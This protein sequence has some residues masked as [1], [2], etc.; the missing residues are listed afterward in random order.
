MSLSS[1][2]ST[3]YVYS[4]LVTRILLNLVK[5]KARCQN[6]YRNFDLGEKNKIHHYS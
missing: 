3:M 5:F 2:L 4:I 6:A 1:Q